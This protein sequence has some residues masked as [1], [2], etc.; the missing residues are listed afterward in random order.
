MT[1]ARTYWKFSALYFVVAAIVLCLAIVTSLTIY[2][3]KQIVAEA[4]RFTHAK[5]A[6]VFS[7]YDNK[8]L[9]IKILYPS[10]WE[11]LEGAGS[12]VF[13]P[14]V[15]VFRS[16]LNASNRNNNSNATQQIKSAVLVV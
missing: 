12:F 6:T 4:E 11:K 1:M 13:S 5:N 7:L 16:H 14:D 8:T 2:L 3:P 10:N 15:V 9:G